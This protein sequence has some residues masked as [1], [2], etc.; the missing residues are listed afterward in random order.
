MQLY[1]GSY[2]W[3][4]F[5]FQPWDEKSEKVSKDI[6]VQLQDVPQAFYST[7]EASFK[8]KE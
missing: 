1:P 4:K 2:D 3:S 5:V 6:E 8:V 7:A